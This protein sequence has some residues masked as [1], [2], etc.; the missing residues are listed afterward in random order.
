[1]GTFSA[2]GFA[3]EPWPIYDSPGAHAVLHEI[4]GLLVYR[5]LGRTFSFF[6]SPQISDE[7]RLT[8]VGL[9]FRLLRCPVGSSSGQQNP[10]TA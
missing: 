5:V 9:G 3:V 2:Q 10:A 7:I 6:P 1:M 4:L 8:P